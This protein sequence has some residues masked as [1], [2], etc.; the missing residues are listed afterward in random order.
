MKD[1]KLKIL[2][3]SSSYLPNIGGIE[4]SLYYLAKAAENDD[5]TI[6]ASD[7]IVHVEDKDERP[8][9]NCKIIRYKLP[10]NKNPLLRVLMNWK[11]AFKAYRNIKREGCDLVIS[12]YHFNTLLCYLAGLKNI[13][14]LVPGVVKYQDSLQL[15]NKKDRSFKRKISYHYNQLLQYLA[16]RVSDRVFVFSENMELQ[17]NSVCKGCETIRTAPGVDT[18]KFFFTEEKDR[19]A[20]NLLTISRINSA[21]NI[22]MAVEALQFLPEEFTLIIVG[23]G[24]TR[25][26]LESLAAKLEIVH[27]V[28]FEGAQTDVVK[29]YSKAHLFLLPSVYEPFGQ[30]ILEA[31][32]CGLP[33]VAFDSSIVNTA[34]RDILGELGCYA[35]ELSAQ[36]YAE[37]IEE[38]YRVFYVDL[39]KSCSDLR[40]LVVNNYSWSELYSTLTRKTML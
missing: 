22:E 12:R 27:R 29:Y 7:N 23:D 26:Q 8:A 3:T 13:N 30:T 16:L 4:N 15:V 39:V 38:G 40:K 32:S 14:F 19:K 34:T 9:L 24:P 20:I 17:V 5:V 11:N 18:D 6:V 36:S 31:S 21:K 28:H 10:N 2:I 35:K 37:A 25:S 1:K 33:T